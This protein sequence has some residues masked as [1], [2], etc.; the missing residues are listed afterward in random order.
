MFF[1]FRDLLIRLGQVMVETNRLRYRTLNE[2]FGS[3]RDTV[4]VVLIT[5]NLEIIKNADKIYVLSAGRIVDF[6]DYTELKNKS[7]I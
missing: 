2:A 3:L 1:L 7:N 4:S 5:H 6:G